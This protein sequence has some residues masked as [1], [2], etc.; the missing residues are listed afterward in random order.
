MWEII[1]LYSLT[2]RRGKSFVSWRWPPALCGKRP[3]MFL[4]TPSLAEFAY[5]NAYYWLT[6]R[7]QHSTPYLLA[8]SGCHMRTVAFQC[9]EW[10]LEWIRSCRYLP[11]LAKSQRS[12]DRSCT[13]LYPPNMICISS[14]RK[15]VINLLKFIVFF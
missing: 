14:A 15:A 11:E 12:F 10:E 1:Q 7:P 6:L 8:C 9:L 13:D 3:C 4:L 2:Y 5:Y